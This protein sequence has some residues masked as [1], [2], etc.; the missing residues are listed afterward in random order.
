MSE[1]SDVRRFG[2]GLEVAQRL[3]R[4]NII[5]N[6]NLIPGDTPAAWD[7]PSGLRIG[8]TEVTRLGMRE[9]QMETIAAFI[10]R[11][12]VEGAAPEQVMDEVIAFREPYQTVYYC[13]EQGLPA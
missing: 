4:A 2:G 1:R 8:T 10:A 12:L 11:V 9:A 6:K 7:H 3:A 5:T 13:F